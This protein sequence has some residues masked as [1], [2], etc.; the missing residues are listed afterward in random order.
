M[1]EQSIQL[2]YRKCDDF[3][4]TSNLVQIEIFV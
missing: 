1:L 3:L 4:V 2:I